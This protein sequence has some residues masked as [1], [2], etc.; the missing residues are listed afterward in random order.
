MLGEAKR[1]SKTKKTPV[2]QAFTFPTPKNA[3]APIRQPQS[4]MTMSEDVGN[5]DEGGVQHPC[6]PH[7]VR[8]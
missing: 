4:N 2:F 6:F 7:Y 5:K 3:A 8:Q 1:C